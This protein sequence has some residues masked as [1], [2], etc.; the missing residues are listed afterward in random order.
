[1]LVL[2]FLHSTCTC[3]VPQIQGSSPW[4]CWLN[5]SRRRAPLGLFEVSRR[6]I[7]TERSLY[8]NYSHSAQK[9]KHSEIEI[10]QARLGS[11]STAL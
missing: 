8:S 4:C 2:Y 6:L 9:P 11:T 3:M 1:M 10:T 5:G 7:Y